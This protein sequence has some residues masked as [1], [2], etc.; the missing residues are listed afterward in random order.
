MLVTAHYDHLGV[1]P[2]LAGDQDLQRGQRRRQRDGS[3]IEMASALASTLKPRPK[4]SLVF[5]TFFGEE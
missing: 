1:W 5:V 3:V 2:S 4:R